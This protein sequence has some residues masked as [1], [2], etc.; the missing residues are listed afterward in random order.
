MRS[1]TC[2]SCPSGSHH[3]ACRY[4]RLGGSIAAAIF[5]SAPVFP[6]AAQRVVKTVIPPGLKRWAL[7]R[8][9]QASLWLQNFEGIYQNFARLGWGRPQLFLYSADDPLADAARIDGLVEEKR[10]RGQDVRARRWDRWVGR[11]AGR[12]ATASHSL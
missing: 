3:T 10:R 12:L 1:S 5:D 2:P 8:Y 11:P 4:S 9:I 7:T 6:D